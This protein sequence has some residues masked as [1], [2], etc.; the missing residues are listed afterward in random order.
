MANGILGTLVRVFWPTPDNLCDPEVR[1]Q[2]EA[3]RALRE[4]TLDSGAA[5]AVR[6]VMESLGR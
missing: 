2:V 1:Q 3:V 4:R 5:E 6:E